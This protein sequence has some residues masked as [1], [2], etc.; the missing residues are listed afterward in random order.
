M[1]SIGEKAMPTWTLL[2]M[3]LRRRERQVA[4]TLKSL[5]ASLKVKVTIVSLIKPSSKSARFHLTIC[6]LVQSLL[7]LQI[8]SQIIRMTLGV[9]FRSK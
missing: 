7:K 2:E 3:K 9:I 4:L 1:A 6:Y 5:L 8:D